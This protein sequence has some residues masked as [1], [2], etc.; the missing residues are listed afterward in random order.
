MKERFMNNKIL[1]VA[2]AAVFIAIGVTACIILKQSKELTAIKSNNEETSAR[3]VNK[4]PAVTVVSQA[5]SEGLPLAL[6]LSVTPFDQ[7]KVA[8]VSAKVGK[9][10]GYRADWFKA[11]DVA[12]QIVL[13]EGLALESGSLTYQG[14][15]T[16]EETHEVKA[17][18][19]AVQLGE[20]ILQAIASG[21][22]PP[23]GR[24]QVSALLFI[25]VRE[26]SVLVSTE[27]FTPEGQETEPR[28]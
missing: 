6:T 16:G 28:K 2:L 12:I 5:S 7:Q 21:D 18:I 20:W 10:Q 3:D 15:L 11:T 24:I 23:Y 14:N 13:P 22:V 17:A 1:I 26:D 27:A 9:L 25:L 19:R 8:V 4:E